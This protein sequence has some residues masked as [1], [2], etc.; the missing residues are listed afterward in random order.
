MTSV[1]NNG[2]DYCTVQ[3]NTIQGSNYQYPICIAFG[4]FTG[5]HCPFLD[6]EPLFD[7]ESPQQF[8]DDYVGRLVIASGKVA[9]DTKQTPEDEWEIKYDKEG[10]T[11][12]DAV[13]MIQLSRKKKDKRVVGV[14]GMSN[15][16]NSRPERMI[17]NSV[18]EG[19]IWVCKS[20]GN[21][22]NGDFIT[23]SDYLGY[24]E[25][26]DDDLFHNYTVGKITIDC[27]FELDSPIMNAKN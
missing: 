13:F 8:K 20:N 9:T 10:I 16:S 2:N 7:N 25:L 24:G 18:G 17:V 3:V 19:A 14:L 12:E 6:N 15:L 26:Q 5:F 23:S 11:I 4:T 22:E 21:F 27:N 1:A